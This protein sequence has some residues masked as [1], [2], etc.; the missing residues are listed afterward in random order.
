MS[1]NLE[2]GKWYKHNR[3]YL[4]FNYKED[5]SIYIL[6]YIILMQFGII[7]IKGMII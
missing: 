2:K 1:V 6:K 4:K 3:G 5:I 7:I